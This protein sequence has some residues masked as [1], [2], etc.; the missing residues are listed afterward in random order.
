MERDRKKIQFV[1]DYIHKEMGISEQQI[2]SK[3]RKKRDFRCK[4]IVFL[5]YEK[6]FSIQF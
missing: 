5:C 6:L 4:K 2:R 3:V 1:F